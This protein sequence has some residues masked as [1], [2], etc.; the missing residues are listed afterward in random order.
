MKAAIGTE[1]FN[2]P[3]VPAVMDPL[4]VLHK[5]SFGAV[6]LHVIRQAGYGIFDACP[7]LAG[8]SHVMG[9][10]FLPADG[11]AL[12]RHLSTDLN[13]SHDRILGN[14]E[15][16]AGSCDAVLAGRPYVI[17]IPIGRIRNDELAIYTRR[18]PGKLPAGIGHQGQSMTPSPLIRA[19]GTYSKTLTYFTSC[20]TSD[21]TS[22]G[23]SCTSR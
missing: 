6:P 20:G 14:R 1:L 16:T 5:G 2:H 13:S 17:G 9:R 22:V 10:K 7:V 8:E 23:D 12:V 15:L 19:P 4:E 21:S 18:T 11:R 3:D